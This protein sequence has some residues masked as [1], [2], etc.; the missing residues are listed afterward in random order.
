MLV[1]AVVL[2]IVFLFVAWLV[3]ALLRDRPRQP[4]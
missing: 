4:G 1:R 3:G 2:L